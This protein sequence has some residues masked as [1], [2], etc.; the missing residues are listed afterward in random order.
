MK[1]VKLKNIAYVLILFFLIYSLVGNLRLYLKA[2]KNLKDAQ[3]ELESESLKN[4]E[5][6]DKLLEV[7]KLSYVERVARDT[8]GLAHKNE[9][10]FVLPPEEVLKKLSPRLATQNTAI[11]LPQI[12]HWQEWLKLFL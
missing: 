4:K 1:N 9:V 5:L 3:T 7:G 6:H 12:P 8:L 10:V 11:K 2:Q